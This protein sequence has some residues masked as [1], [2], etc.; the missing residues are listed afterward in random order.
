[1]TR[2]SVK[3][4]GEMLFERYL[5]EHDLKYEYQPDLGKG[6][7][8]DYLVKGQDASPLCEVTD[9]EI[10]EI[11]K[12]VIAQLDANRKEFGHGISGS[13]AAGVLSIDAIQQRIRDKLTRELGQLGP[14]RGRYP[15]VVV[16]H[17][18]GTVVHLDDF[19][20][21]GAMSEF[22]TSQLNV[23]LSAVA[24]VRIV[25]PGV[26]IKQKVLR[27]LKKDKAVRREV[28][29]SGTWPTTE[30]LAR[31]YE[32]LE[33]EDRAWGSSINQEYAAL[34]VYHNGYASIPIPAK[35]FPGPNASHAR[36]IPDRYVRQGQFLKLQEIP[37]RLGR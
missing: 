5:D 13:H 4:I 30:E 15:L 17:N 25:R 11:D 1:M 37:T 32:A 34:R 19:N 16:L 6:K 36:L 14:F 20:I 26:R 31:S 35:T 18:H 8:P 10:G 12:P 21:V 9:L 29:R 3:P 2:K 7:L 24:V 23:D 33:A 28:G 27:G 22:L